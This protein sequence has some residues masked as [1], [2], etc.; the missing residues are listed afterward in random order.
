MESNGRHGLSCKKQIGR[1]S[2]HDEVNKLIKRAIVQ[3][4]IPAVLEPSNLS[5]EDGK[6]PDG[7]TLSTWKSGKCLIWDY[8]C[9]DSLCATYV[10][11]SSKQ[12]GAA[13][14]LRENKKIEK[15]SSLSNYY[16]VPVAVETF[17]SWGSCGL[18]LIKEIGKKL[19]EVTN[20]QRS[21]FFLSQN[22]SIAI[23]RGNASCVMGTAPRTEGLD[24]IYYYIDHNSDIDNNLITD[25][26]GT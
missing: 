18:K 11:S 14:N 2:R 7:L 10:K 16:F 15:Y 4:K 8:S 3:A 22:I 20:E 13:A 17:G 9:A 19:K 1:R 23:Q 21:T 5:R 6:R 26:P 24:S 25:T 12:A